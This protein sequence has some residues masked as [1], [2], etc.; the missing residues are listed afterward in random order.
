VLDVYKAAAPHIDLLAPDIYMPDY[1]LY[2]TVLERYS[3]ADNPL[4]VAETGNRDEYAR[5][6]FAALGHQA[7]G[8]SPFGIDFSAYS[9]WPL[10]AKEVSAETLQP[11]A[12][13]YR[14]VA[15]AM[16]LI[17]KASFEGRVH[18]TAEAPGEPV[19]TLPID[20]NWKAVITYGVPQFYFT[21]KPPGNEQPVG[22]A[23]I[24][25]LAA[26]E[27]LVTAIHA[28]VEII[29]TDPARRARQIFEY[30]DE[31]SYDDDSEWVFRRRW[32]GDQTDYGL[33]FSNATE[34]LRVKLATY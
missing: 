2:T 24:V 3:R 1:A 19:Q 28:R 21:G 31:G 27:F 16:R 34:L 26:D 15:P 22:S 20:A 13:N 8:W 32:N 7:I 9:N 17:A 4:F 25:Q 6:F 23:L 10:G 14:L 11:F 30:V 29:A 5:Y 33:N 18:G 12:L